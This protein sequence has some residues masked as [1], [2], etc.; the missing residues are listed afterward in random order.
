MSCAEGRWCEGTGGRWPPTRQEERPWEKLTLLIPWSWISSCQNCET[1]NF[2]SLNP[3]GCALAA[4]PNS[5]RHPSPFILPLFS[6]PSLGWPVRLT[7]LFLLVKTYPTLVSSGPQWRIFTQNHH[8][9]PHQGGLDLESCQEN[10]VN[11]KTLDCWASFHA[12]R[13]CFP[14]FPF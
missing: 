8:F 9:L 5:H 10:S 11:P 7:L 4:L 6:L 2:C 12:H 14:L 1:I 13:C 3:P